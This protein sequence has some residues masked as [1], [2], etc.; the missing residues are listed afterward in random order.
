VPVWRG[1]WWGWLVE[2]VLSDEFVD[3]LLTARRREK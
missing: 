2:G 1:W 3:H